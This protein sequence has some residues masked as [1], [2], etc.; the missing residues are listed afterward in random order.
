MVLWEGFAVEPALTF[1]INYCEMWSHSNIFPDHALAY[2]GSMQ[3]LFVT[4]QFH[5]YFY[6]EKIYLLFLQLTQFMPRQN[7]P[8][9]SLQDLQEITVTLHKTL[10]RFLQH[11][12]DFLQEYMTFFFCMILQVFLQDRYAWESLLLNINQYGIN[13]SDQL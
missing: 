2:T 9:R 11:W 12:G 10:A 1:P 13:G 8:A 3:Y 5:L 6:A 7:N 4:S